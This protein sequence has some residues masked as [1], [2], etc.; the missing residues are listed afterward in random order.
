M[1]NFNPGD[2]V[3]VKNLIN[4]KIYNETSKDGN[5]YHCVEWVNDMGAKTYTYHSEDN[6]QKEE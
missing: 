1:S 5:K 6:L 2:L 4:G 3:V